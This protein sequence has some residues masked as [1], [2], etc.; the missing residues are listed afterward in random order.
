M[1]QD[2]I[3]LLLSM[4][5]HPEQYTDEQIEKMLAED[6][7]LAELIEQLALT[8]R[9]FVKCEVDE[10]DVAVDEE[11][12]KFVG[13][14]AAKM[15]RPQRGMFYKVAASIVGILLMA[16][17]TF[18]AIHIVRTIVGPNN[19][20]EIEQ[21]VTTGA[22][23]STSEVDERNDGKNISEPIVFDNVPLEKMLMQI[24]AYYGKEVEFQNDDARQFRFYF[25]WRPQESLDATM[26]RLNLFE[27]ITVELNDNKL[28]VK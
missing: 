14:H 7:E 8:K 5:E 18:A 10:E 19:D 12:K 9:A 11:W 6:P 22:A 26:R 17:V 3:N 2:K 4:Q 28:I 15:D 23:P 20:L 21:A 24:A 1:K 16:G 13:E 27:S 25:V